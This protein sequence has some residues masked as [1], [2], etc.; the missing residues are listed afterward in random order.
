MNFEILIHYFDFNDKQLLNFQKLEG[1]H[2]PSAH[3][4]SL[5]LGNG[6]SQA[7]NPRQ[8]LEIILHWLLY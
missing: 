6:K 5:A 8:S 7:I 4:S 3:N 2:L 1:L